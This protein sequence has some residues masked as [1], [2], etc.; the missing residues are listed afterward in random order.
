MT[1]EHLSFESDDPDEDLKPFPF[2]LTFRRFTGPEDGDGSR[3]SERVTETFT[4]RP[5]VTAGVLAG[6]EAMWGA[7]RSAKG[8]GAVFDLFDAALV[9]DDLVRFRRLIEDPDVFLDGK[10][11]GKLAESLYAEYT[12]RPT[13]TPA[14]S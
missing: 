6:I 13:R 2:D 9:P 14:G 3:P 11:L 1:A 7:S 4:C 8:A 5:Y 12:R 10:V